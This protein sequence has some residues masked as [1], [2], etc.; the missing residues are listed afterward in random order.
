MQMSTNK[1]LSH[2]GRWVREF[3]AARGGNVALTFAIATIPIIGTVG[4]AI[5]YSHANSIKAALQS[6]LDS[7]GLMLSREAVW[8]KAMMI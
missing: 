4:A 7:T 5:D 6:A 8:M 1:I 3:L 2:I